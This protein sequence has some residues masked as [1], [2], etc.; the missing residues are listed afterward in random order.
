MRGRALITLGSG[1]RVVVEGPADLS[2]VDDNRL[3]LDKGRLGATVPTQAV[4]FTVDTPLGE[5]VDL[6][7][8]FTLDLTTATTCKLYVF[9]GL[10]EVRPQ[11]GGGRPFQVAQTQAVSYDS[12]TDAAELIPIGD[13]EKLDL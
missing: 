8:E 12:A 11:R 2:I 3:R 10:V 5:F 1:A 7:T 6:G 9:T 4:G 13:G